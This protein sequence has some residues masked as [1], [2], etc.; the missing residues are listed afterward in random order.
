[1]RSFT[2]RAPPTSQ[3]NFLNACDRG[4]RFSVSY[5]TSTLRFA[6]ILAAQIRCLR[7]PRRLVREC[8]GRGGSPPLGAAYRIVAGAISPSLRRMWCPPS[9]T[10]DLDNFFATTPPDFPI[11]KFLSSVSKVPRYIFHA[12]RTRVRSGVFFHKKKGRGFFTAKSPSR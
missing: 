9:M 2:L 10:N 11:L 12:S 8:A 5:S 3:S 4:T 7:V 6:R 1:M